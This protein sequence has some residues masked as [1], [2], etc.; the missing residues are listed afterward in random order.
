MD[1]PQC[2]M[3]LLERVGSRLNMTFNRPE[4]RNAINNQMGVEFNAVVEWL[5][6][7]S[8]IRLVVLRGA[9]GHF[10]A[11]GDIKERLSL[12]EG[13]SGSDENPILARNIRAGMGF[14]RFSHVPQ[15]TIAMVEGSAFGGGMGYAC[16]ADITIV[17]RSARMGMPETAL[18]IAPAQ[19]APHVVKRVGLTRARQLALTGE[20][21]GGE[22]AFEYGVAQYVCD[23]ENVESTLESVVA[24]VLRGAP[25]AGAVTKEIMRHVGTMSDEEMIRFSAERFAELNRGDEGR[26]GQ[27]AFAEKRLPAWQLT[28]HE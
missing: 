11:G 16:I 14:L 9:G 1:L 7:H 21:F 8:E 3:L 6:N 24:K 4:R 17:A 20:R 27:A 2:T 22:K 13:C 10:C 12:V 19:I 5:H 23:D 25:R 15:T 28:N 26:E 18:G